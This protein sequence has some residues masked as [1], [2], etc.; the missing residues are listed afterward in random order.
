MNPPLRR[1]RLLSIGVL[2]ALAAGG[3]FGGYLAGS[4]LAR[5][6]LVAARALVDQLQPENLRLKR[7][8][9]DQN[10]QLSALE[11]RATN[12]EN[13]LKAIMPA[14]NT[15]NVNPNQSLVVANGR[16]T[17]ALI[18]PPT[19]QNVQININGKQY[20]AVSGDVIRVALD[21]SNACQVGVQSFDMFK[22][23]LTA[24][25]AAPKAQ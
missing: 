23:V 18:G 2:V 1:R 9:I 10:A 4:D 3:L 24:S 19:N 16:L 22:A 20:S 25:C 8:A 21:A 15:F 13:M 7:Q 11:A 5:R 17:I 14:E 6:D 12:S